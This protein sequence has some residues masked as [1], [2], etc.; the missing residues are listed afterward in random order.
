MSPDGRLRRTR[1]SPRRPDRLRRGVPILVSAAGLT[2][3]TVPAVP[4]LALLAPIVVLAAAA[5]WGSPASADHPEPGWVA[6]GLAV[7]ATGAVGL[8]LWRRP[9]LGPAEPLVVAWSL[10]TTL[11]AW[12][13]VSR[14]P[15]PTGRVVVGVAA[16][17]VCA[18]GVTTLPQVP[19][20]VHHLHLAAAEALADGRSPWT[21]LGVTDTSPIAAEEA[22]IDGYPY[23]V[24]T[25]LITA[26]G[27][28]AGD[29][30]LA[31]WIAW[32]IGLLVLLARAAPSS[33]RVLVAGAFLAV[34]TPVIMIWSWTEPVTLA[35]IAVAV[36]LWRR[37]VLSPVLLGL[38]L[39][40]K[41]YLVVLAPVVALM[42]TTPRRR[43][44]TLVTAA[45]ATLSGLLLGRGY[46]DALLGFHAGRPVRED[47]T[48]LPGLLELGA[49]DPIVL[50][51]AALLVAAGLGVWSARRVVGPR[52]LM[53][54]AAGVLATFFLLS[55]QAF[56]NYWWLVLGLVVVGEVVACQGS[57]RMSD[58]GP[59]TS[60][61]RDPARAGPRRREGR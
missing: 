9:E 26:S 37:P 52:S 55:A 11:A 32:L 19:I 50:N 39:A 24:V 10:G 49:T 27:A 30:R 34:P 2:L 31:L 53:L 45:A 29:P 56:A 17:V 7:G 57:P 5:G 40:T 4:G 43:I 14:R 8:L 21:G 51:S 60:R 28:V 48:N 15:G 18:V 42:R 20:D 3:L 23:P 47:S 13:A 36:A 61:R 33:G 22:V 44:L 1:R 25:L 54:V 41:Q 46:P 12:L 35:G 59:V 58:G 16:T 38:A 6:T